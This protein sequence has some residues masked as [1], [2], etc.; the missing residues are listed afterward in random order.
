[1]QQD[2]RC[3]RDLRRTE[4]GINISTGNHDAP[5][6][7]AWGGIIRVLIEK[8][9]VH[10]FLKM[11]QF[12]IQSNADK[13]ILITL[14]YSK[15]SQKILF[16][17]AEKDFVDI[18]IGFLT[19]PIGCAIKLLFESEHSCNL[20][21]HSQQWYVCCRNYPEVKTC[22]DQFPFRSYWL[23]ILLSFYSVVLVVIKK[24]RVQLDSGKV[25]L[26]LL[27]SYYICGACCLEIGTI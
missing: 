10:R 11:S 8:E 23:N 5:L 18:V 4:R 15:S 7:T 17:E 13:E 19:L 14:L 22:N 3:R 6:A 2:L 1:M 26:H 9:N 25:P 16:V 12:M 24:F 20:G 27:R 21:L